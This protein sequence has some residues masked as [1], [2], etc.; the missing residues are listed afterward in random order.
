MAEN[1]SGENN[2]MNISGWLDER[3][4]AIKTAKSHME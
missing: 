2:H 1:D 3:D 4:L